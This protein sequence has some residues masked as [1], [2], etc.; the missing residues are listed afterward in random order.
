MIKS[1][2]SAQEQELKNINPTLKEIQQSNH[3]IENSIAFLTE[4]N[5]EFK[6]KIKQLELQAKEDRKYITILEDK[7]EDL[8]KGYR[9][10]NF[11]MKNVPKKN[12][13]TKED[14]IDMV[15]CL[16]KFVGSSIGKS[17]IKDIYRVRGKR[18]GITNTPIVVETSSTLQKNDLLKMCKAYNVKHKDK[19]CAKHLGFHIFEDTPIFISEQ[20]TAKGARLHFLARDLVKTKAYKFCWTAYGKV[21]VR[22]DENSPTIT[23]TNEAQVHQMLQGK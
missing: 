2:F 4:Q 16:S 23:I 6:K 13:E 9:K 11:E 3:N 1:L 8:Q 17:D 15:T 14:L 22:K 21:Y 10:T 5:E 19:L 12:I 7:L 20:L 18:E